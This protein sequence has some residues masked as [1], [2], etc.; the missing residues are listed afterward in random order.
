MTDNSEKASSEQPNESQPTPAASTLTAAL[1]KGLVAFQAKVPTIEKTQTAKVQMKAGGSYSY[2]YADLGDIWKA[3]RSP[4]AEAKLAVT[5]TL[6]GG[7]NGKTLLTTT[8]WHENGETYTSELQLDTGSRSPQEAAS[9]FTYYKRYTLSAVLGIATEEDDDGKG[10]SDSAPSKTQQSAPRAS[11]SK[12]A[13]D[14]QKGLLRSLMEAAG[15]DPAAIKARI[16]LIE[17]SA[18]ASSA[19]E[20]MQE[21]LSTKE[22]S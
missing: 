21:R 22:E 4:L 11:A 19:I 10:A 18:E 9:V 1:A 6:S 7:T 20:K 2:K 5:Q 13:S 16:D 12:P 8:V 14:K 15:I 3:I 17:T